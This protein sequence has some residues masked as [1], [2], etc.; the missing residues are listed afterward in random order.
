ME[1]MNPELEYFSKN[2]TS[3]MALVD[4]SKDGIH[5]LARDYFE[6]KDY[7]GSIALCIL[8][9]SKYEDNDESDIQEPLILL[10]INLYQCGLTKRA[11]LRPLAISLLKKRKTSINQTLKKFSREAREI[12]VVDLAVILTIL[13][14]V[15]IL[16]SRGVFP[17]SVDILSRRFFQLAMSF[18]ARISRGK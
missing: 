4:E 10:A 6:L 7:S 5:N 12:G 13:L 8:C 18:V 15:T 16:E 17:K 11:Y 2:G 9:L 14:R 3:V 1:I